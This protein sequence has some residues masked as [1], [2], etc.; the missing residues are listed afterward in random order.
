MRRDGGRL[1][2]NPG[3]L[4]IDPTRRFR[5]PEIQAPGPPSRVLLGFGDEIDEPLH[6]PEERRFQVTEA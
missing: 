3:E 1:W 4:R 6:R 5:R 2:H